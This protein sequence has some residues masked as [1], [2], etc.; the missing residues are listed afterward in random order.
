MPI[1]G[2]RWSSLSPQEMN[3]RPG[4]PLYETPLFGDCYETRARWFQNFAD[5]GDDSALEYDTTSDTIAIEHNGPELGREQGW[6][7][8]SS[9]MLFQPVAEYSLTSQGNPTPGMGATGEYTAGQA[10]IDN[11]EIESSDGGPVN[12]QHPPSPEDNFDTSLPEPV[13]AVATADEHTEPRVTRAAPAGGSTEAGYRRREVPENIELCMRMKMLKYTFG[14]E[15]A[16][17]LQ[18]MAPLCFACNGEHAIR[19]CNRYRLICEGPGPSCSMVGHHSSGAVLCPL[20]HPGML[21]SRGM[22]DTPPGNEGGTPPGGGDSER[23]TTGVIVLAKYIK[24]EVVMDEANDVDPEVE[25]L[26]PT[27]NT[28]GGRVEVNQDQDGHS[29]TGGLNQEVPEA[30]RQ[31]ETKSTGSDIE[32]DADSGRASLDNGLPETPR[33]GVEDATPPEP[34]AGVVATGDHKDTT[35]SSFEA[36]DRNVDKMLTSL[37]NVS[38]SEE[39]DNPF[40]GHAFQGR[41]CNSVQD[42]QLH[43]SQQIAKTVN[44]EREPDF[45]GWEKYIAEIIQGWDRAIEEGFRPPYLDRYIITILDCVVLRGPLAILQELHGTNLN[46]T[47]TLLIVTNHV[48]TKAGTMD[49]GIKTLAMLL[50]DRLLKVTGDGSLNEA[51]KSV[52]PP[53]RRSGTPASASSGKSQVRRSGAADAMKMMS[54]AEKQ[55]PGEQQ[56]QGQ[57]WGQTVEEGEIP[58][59][60][61]RRSLKRYRPSRAESSNKTSD[62]PG[63]PSTNYG[64]GSGGYDGGRPTAAGS[65]STRYGGGSSGPDG[66]RPAATRTGSGALRATGGYSSGRSATTGGEAPKPRTTRKRISPPSPE[67]QRYDRYRSPSFEIRTYSR[68]GEHDYREATHR[69]SQD[70]DDDDPE[71]TGWMKNDSSIQRIAFRADGTFYGEGYQSVKRER[72]SYRKFS[73]SI[74]YLNFTYLLS[75]TGPEL[76][77][78]HQTKVTI[79]MRIRNK[80]AN[81]SIYLS[82]AEAALLVDIIH[83]FRGEYEAVTERGQAGRNRHAQQYAWLTTNTRRLALHTEAV[84]AFDISP[85]W[86]GDDHG[87]CL[88]IHSVIV[89]TTDAMGGLHSGRD[90]RFVIPMAIARRLALSIQRLAVG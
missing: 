2:P 29:T 54:L 79:T 46:L 77:G 36:I 41:S 33:T 25:A 39:R 87:P 88:T 73:D 58:E 24:T 4:S 3:M 10:D 17:V 53:W 85:G 68:Y 76:T 50:G 16:V 11:G 15:I 70:S 90:A 72:H 32:N 75:L 1:N 66:G 40:E 48:L 84:R 30:G 8:E 35:A 52:Q 14:G 65:G 59:R 47:R 23:P 69:R 80:S 7:V 45:P 34:E 61:S 38:N 82:P 18:R 71:G 27:P 78:C 67:K 63:K 74:E 20:W 22:T 86:C 12:E 5:L 21:P 89:Q 26:Q 43:L 56:W 6:P 42:V 28:D 60:H 13:P 64:Y 51:L 83:A 37:R 9:H 49:P 62:R 19:Y 81:P 31:V 44:G 55:L 57:A